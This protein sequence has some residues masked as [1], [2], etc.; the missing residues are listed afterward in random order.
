MQLKS[1][2]GIDGMMRASDSA[3]SDLIR[4]GKLNG[5]GFD[6]GTVSLSVAQ[7]LQGQAERIR[8]QSVNSILQIGKALIEAKRHLSHGG[9][10]NWVECE[11]GIPARTAQ[12]YMR[13]ANWASGKSAKLAHLPPSAIYLLSAAN[14]PEE[15]VH[16]VLNRIDAGE[17][18]AFS[19]VREELKAFQ[20]K[21]KGVSEC[22]QSNDK[23]HMAP[24]GKNH[25]VRSAV[26]GLV[27]LLSRKLSP[28]DFARVCAMFTDKRI[29]SDPDLI[30]NLVD[31]FRSIVTKNTLTK[32]NKRQARRGALPINQVSDPPLQL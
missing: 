15:F 32:Y 23:N 2:L 16:Q 30:Q 4:G 7:F 14:V 5:K 20:C 6:Y 28:E 19:V 26:T 11:V 13:A 3:S 8:R 27:A 17:K 12:T 10:V 18:I 9:F 1:S 21:Q 29:I 22:E 31:E 25:D 24:L